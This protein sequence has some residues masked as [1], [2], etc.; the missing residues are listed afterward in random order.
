M[1]T[2]INYTDDMVQQ[3]REAAPLNYEKAEVLAELLNKNVRS[4]IA[5][6]KKENIEYEAKKP[7]AKKRTEMTKAEMTLQIIQLGNFP[8]K[9]LAG[10]EKSPVLALKTL[11]DFM[12]SLSTADDS[13]V[14]VSD[15]EASK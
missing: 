4:I 2:K 5:K 8:A 6:A 7:A 10:L 1:T 11:L 13:E 15:N 14:E 12:Q 3:M 9:A